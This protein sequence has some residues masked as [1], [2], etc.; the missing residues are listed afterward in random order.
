MKTPHIPQQ[1]LEFRFVHASGPGGQ[2]VNKTATAVELRVQLSALE[3]APDT[4]R[5]LRQQQRNRINK[6]GELVV[7]AERYR[8]QL[9]NR[10]DALARLED[11]I[12]QA[13][14]RPKQRIATRPSNA[15]QQRRLDSKTLRGRTKQQRKKPSL[16]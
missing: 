2:H 8:S 6:E 14:I 13:S 9:K 5:R 3:L 15:A 11:I 10:Q 7:F 4:L 12:A 1:A 16:D